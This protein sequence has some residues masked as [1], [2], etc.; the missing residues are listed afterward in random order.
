MAPLI[1]VRDCHGSAVWRVRVWRNELTCKVCGETFPDLWQ[2]CPR[3]TKE[4]WEIWREGEDSSEETGE[5]VASV[6][7][8]KDGEYELV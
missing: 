1:P 5:T 7:Y 6:S 4:E 3:C 2:R 8:L